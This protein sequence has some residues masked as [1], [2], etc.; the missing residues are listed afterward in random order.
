MRLAGLAGRQHGV[1]SRDQMRRLGLA[2]HS[3]AHSVAGGRLH[4][5]FHG[6][7]AVG[8][9]AISRPGRLLA[10]LLACGSGSVVSHRT[11]A[12]LLGL[13]DR[14]PVLID[15][16]API[17]A[18]RKI[19]G[20]RRRFVPPPG[21]DETATRDSIACTS[22][23][24]T[25]VDLAGISN[26][27]SLSRTIERAAVNGML[28]VSGIE[29]ALATRR[30]RGAPTLRAILADWM[31][32]AGNAGGPPRLRSDFEARVLA[33]LR[34]ANLPAP[35]CN[36]VVETAGGGLEVD[37]L[38]RGARVVMELD[39]HRY[40]GT[41]VA[42]ERDRSRDRHL[43][44]AGYRVLRATWRQIERE[45][46]GLTGAIARLLDQGRPAHTTSIGS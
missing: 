39:G 7:Y 8:H 41:R 44:L 29:R 24:R 45:P 2:D 36:V 26:R 23:S 35:Q 14:P 27:R 19:E 25:V 40:H 38:W 10:A 22:P 37:M 31:P 5:V 43:L 17:E 21:E 1:V 46:K 11:A 15:V 20:I 3:I 12:A 30:R 42:Y 13:I 34:A 18:G 9:A 33:L 16:I 28:D 4:P 32:A 6:V